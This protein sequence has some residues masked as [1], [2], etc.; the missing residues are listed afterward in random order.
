MLQSQLVSIKGTVEREGLVI[1][2]VAGHI[3]TL[4]HIFAAAQNIGP[5]DNKRGTISLE[6]STR[7]DF[8]PSGEFFT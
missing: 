5:I 8:C 1:H 7:Q 4:D 2:V 3:E 6:I